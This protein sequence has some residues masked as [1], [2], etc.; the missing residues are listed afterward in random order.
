MAQASAHSLAALN[1]V[2][3]EVAVDAMPYVDPEYADPGTSSAWT[4]AEGAPA[5]RC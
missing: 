3:N 5:L 1:A 2:A 4:L